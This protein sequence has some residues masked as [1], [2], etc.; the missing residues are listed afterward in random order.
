MKETVIP[1]RAAPWM[2]VL[3]LSGLV[4][5][6]AGG[7]YFWPRPAPDVP[8]PARAPAFTGDIAAQVHHFCAA[9][10]AYP[11]AETFP[12]HVWKE[13]VERGYR[14]FSHSAMPLQPPPIDEV[15]K[16][17]EARAP[18]ALPPAEIEPADGPPPVRFEPVRYP[19]PPGASPPAIAHVNLVALYGDRPR[20]VL[21]CEMRHGL[22]M[23]LRPYAKAPAWEVL[24]RLSN[25]AHAEV[26]DLDGDG[27]KDL[28]VADLGSF[29]PTDRR[30]GKVVW[31]RGSPGGTYT[32]HTVLED[33]GRIA[34]VRAADFRGTGKLD[35]VVAA[36]GWNNIGE[37]I[38]LEN[39]TSDWSTPKFVPRVLDE[40]HGAIHVPVTDLDK[41]GRPDFVALLSQEHEAVVAFLNA[42]G[43]KFRKE[44]L[45]AA[46]HPGYGSSGIELT[47][48]DGDGD[49]DVLYSNGDIL[50]A[51]YLLKPYHGVQ[52]LEN[53]GP[54]MGA[55][56]H[57]P[58][59][60][61]YGAHRAVAADF[62]GKG[63]KDIAAVSFLPAEAF[64]QREK[65]GLDAVL[66]LERTG[67]RRFA[68]HSLQ[69]GACNHVTCAAGDLFGTGRADLVTANFTSTKLDHVLTV[70][71]NAGP[72]NVT[73]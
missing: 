31:L 27:T 18:E 71:K 16:Y 7:Y 9:C 32:P 20:D 73:E 69:A 15:V 64:P 50:D 22:V 6:A 25:P 17:Y 59:T 40:R 12:R 1:R 48:L 24:A 33:V 43:G 58:V 30:C 47:D 4:L 5:V 60:A 65:L 13:E 61:L 21:A 52:W 46:S 53:P 11:P 23:A 44:T 67:P 41:D 2:A 51:P 55:W 29:A 49:L 38:L 63:T 36:F 37:V 39:H 56:A 26:V 68:R 57:H 19:G 62:T 3:V 10:H 72:A 35:L 42:G 14:F 45:Y 66:F 28:L 54:G 8:P 34:D 70:W